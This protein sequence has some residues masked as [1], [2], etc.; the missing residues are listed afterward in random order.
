MI[1]RTLS[2]PDD[3]GNLGGG[4]GGDQGD[5]GTGGA[6]LLDPN[7]GG[8]GE[9][10]REWMKD[11][12]EALRGSKSLRKFS[13]Q[14]WKENLAK[15]YAELES[16]LGGMVNIPTAK[17]PQ[18]TWDKFY[19]RVGR[20]KA[21]D[22]YAIKWSFVDEAVA[23]RVSAALAKRQQEDAEAYTAKVKEADMALR[24]EY[25]AQYEERLALASKAY[26]AIFD[27]AAKEAIA[28]AGLNNNPVFIKAM[29]VIGEQVKGD[30]FLKGAGSAGDK[31]DPL[32][33]MDKKYAS[34]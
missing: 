4:Q 18:E 25:G 33:W 1:V 32:S 12:P 34:R 19:E 15:S 13:D 31:E 10:E 29:A 30:G 5:Q 7:R 2:I 6:G 27:Q 3:G 23:S 9:P 8:Q 17:D 14:S 28:K 21:P 26:D 11:L 22:G 24:K 20:L 16:K